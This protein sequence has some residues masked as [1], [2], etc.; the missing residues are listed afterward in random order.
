MSREFP[1]E[2]P[3][4]G[5]D[6]WKC[7][8][9]G[10]VFRDGHQFQGHSCIPEMQRQYVYERGPP[11]PNDMHMDNPEKPYK[12]GL[13]QCS[14]ATSVNLSS[15]M[16]LHGP[17]KQFDCHNCGKMFAHAAALNRHKKAPGEC[18]K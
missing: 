8:K 12:C 11:Q 1:D 4:Q 9:C 5:W 2:K 6:A 3:P 18:A 14:F 16:R 13:C 10:K 7:T 17:D 15:H